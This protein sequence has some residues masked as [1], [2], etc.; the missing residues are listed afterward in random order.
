MSALVWDHLW[1]GVLAA[2]AIVSAPCTVGYPVCFAACCGAATL[3][4]ELARNDLIDAF[5][6]GGRVSNAPSSPG[7]RGEWAY[8]AFPKE[9]DPTCGL[10]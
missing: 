7:N 2:C 1:P 3:G 5:Y 9:D 4:V 6:P 10:D 8:C